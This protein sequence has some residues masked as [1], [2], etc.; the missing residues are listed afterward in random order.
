VAELNDGSDTQAAQLSPDGLTIYFASSRPE[1]VG[2]LTSW[3]ATRSSVDAAWGTPVAMPELG[4]SVSPSPCLD[5]THILFNRFVTVGSS[6]HSDLFETVD[7]EVAPIA[8]LNSDATE[9]HPWVSE[10]C[11]TLY[12]SSDRAGPSRVHVARRPTID[13]PFEITDVLTDVFVGDEF[14]EILDP[15]VSLD[16]QHLL[17]SANAEDSAWFDVYEASR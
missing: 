11:L 10:D 6:G 2:T 16:G 13:D 1:A 12:F 15:R 14:V 9:R 3:R 17:F 5:G 4:E 8:E 7:G